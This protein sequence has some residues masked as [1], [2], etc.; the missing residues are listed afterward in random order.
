[1]QLYAVNPVEALS[2]Y[3]LQS[4]NIISYWE[5]KAAGGTAEKAIQYK[6]EEPLLSFIQAIERAEDEARGIT[7]GF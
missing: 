1:M 4:I 2:I 5:W 3:F 6:R 7:S